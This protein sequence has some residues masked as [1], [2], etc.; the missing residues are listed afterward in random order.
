MSDSEEKDSGL[1]LVG[2]GKLAKAIPSAVYTQTAKTALTTF[3]KVVAPITESLHGVGRWVRQKFDTMVEVEKAIAAYT[4]QEA[5]ERAKARLKAGDELR[6]PSHEKSFVIAFEQASKEVDPLLHELWTNLL[7][8][9]LSDEASH[10]HFVELLAHLGPS[11]AALLISLK[12]FPQPTTVEDYFAWEPN[13]TS[14]RHPGGKQ[15]TDGTLLAFFFMILGSRFQRLGVRIFW[16]AQY[17]STAPK[18]ETHF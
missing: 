14:W 11:E 15:F 17:C 3:E 10:P 8:S 4:I 7:A 6:K 12:S 16:T 18:L 5:M 9:Q 13:L 1:D 2:I